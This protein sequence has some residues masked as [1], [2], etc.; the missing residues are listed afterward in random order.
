MAPP[1]GSRR[2]ISASGPTSRERRWPASAR[3]IKAQGAA[4]GIQLAHAGRKAS[5]A[6]A[7]GGR[8]A[9]AARP[10]AGG[11]LW[12][13]ARS[14]SAPGY[15]EPHEL[16]PRR[17]RRVVDEFA[18]A[19]RRA[20]SSRLRRH[21]TARRAWLPAARVSVAA[22]QRA[23][24]RVRR[25][26]SRTACAS[27]STVAAA[28][29]K[30]GPR[31]SRCSCGSRPPT[32]WTAAGRW[33]TR[34]SSLGAWRRSAWTWSTVRAEARCEREDPGGPGFPGA[35]CRGG[36]AEAGVATGAVGM[37]PAPSR[38]SRSSPPAQADAVL[39]ARELLRNPYWPLVAAAG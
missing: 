9:I 28:C 8:A 21:R 15:T 31:R 36:A 19:A 1:A 7:V 22:D 17:D 20:E 27:R 4:A 23:H 2:P 13:R 10:M 14:R 38:P 30:P 18:A 39:L 25:Q 3:V 34:S 5:T 26:R 6:A 33:T 16:S 24:R 29:V 12:R 35:V 11:R 32:G 37:V